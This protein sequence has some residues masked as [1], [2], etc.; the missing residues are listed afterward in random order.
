M[1]TI[2]I[3]LILLSSCKTLYTGTSFDGHTVSALTVQGKSFKFYY[4]T[5]NPGISHIHIGDLKQTQLANCFKLQCNV[6]SDSICCLKDRLFEWKKNSLQP[7]GGWN[8][9]KKKVFVWYKINL[10]P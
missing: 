2:I 1:K 7:V 4:S 8:M 3:P 6:H 10:T 5:K 9:K